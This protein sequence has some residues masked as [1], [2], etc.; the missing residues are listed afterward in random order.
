MYY[1]MYYV[2]MYYN[3]YYVLMYYN[4]LQYATNKKKSKIYF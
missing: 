1:N 2:L 3:M 4:V